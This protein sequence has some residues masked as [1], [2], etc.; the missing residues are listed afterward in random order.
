MRLHDIGIQLVK[1]PT[2]QA[3]SAGRR[4][5]VGGGMG[6][7]PMIAPELR[8]F[9]GA[10]DLLS[11]LEAALR[12]Y[13]RY[14]RRDN[15]YKARIKILG[16]RDRCRRVSPPG[17]G[18]VGRGEGARPR[19]ARRRTRRGSPRCSRLPPSTP[20]EVPASRGSTAATP[21]SRCGS[22]RT[23]ARTSSRATRS[24]TISLKPVG[25]IPGDATAEQID[26]MADLAERFRFDELRVTHSQNIVLPHV[27]ECDLSDLWT[28]LD[29]AGLAD[30]N[31]DLITDIIACPGLDYCSLANARSIP[32]AQKIAARFA[33][34]RAAARPGR[35]EAEDQRLHQRLRPPSCRPYRH[36][37]RRQERHRELPAAARRIGCG[38]RQPRPHHRPRLLRG[39]HRRRD[40]AGHRQISAWSAKKANASST[41]IAASASIRSRR[42]S[43][44][45]RLAKRRS[46]D[47]ARDE[48]GG[49]AP[50]L[51][52]DRCRPLK[53]AQARGFVIADRSASAP[54]A[55][56]RT[57]GHARLV[58]GRPDQRHRRPPRVGRRCPR[59]APASRPAVAGRGE[60]PDRSATGAAI[61]PPRILREAGYAGELRAAGDVLVDQMPFMRRC[62]FDS[63][64]P[65]HPSTRRSCSAPR[66]LRRPST[67]PPPTA[68]CPIWALRH[69]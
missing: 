67:S 18:G 12:V 41:P 57:H 20:R 59:A 1:A 35:A 40:R 27:H 38:G 34:P 29:G 26:L 54:T 30:P 65:R 48:P 7:T 62:G 44:D 56:R 49:G 45:E 31:L 10:D 39:R 11:Y 24:S 19:P 16:P 63:S 47:F 37:G 58:P 36:P 60:L 64:P 14:G 32:V 22:T 53:S 42:R 15:I 55:A 61:P 69:G 52:P 43:M 6:R 9:I 17:R 33:S 28:A 2:T 4:I 50:T 66:P 13:N 51:P 46:L 23:S 21:I 3:R 68:R 25:G 5:F 8:D